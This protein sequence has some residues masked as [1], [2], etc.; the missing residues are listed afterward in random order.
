[1][2]R[3][4]KALEHKIEKLDAAEKKNAGR[5]KFD[6]RKTFPLRRRRGGIAERRL[7]SSYGPANDL[8][9][10]DFSASAG[11]GSGWCVMGK[12][13]KKKKRRRANRRCL[14][15]GVSRPLG[16]RTAATSASGASLKMGY[17]SPAGLRPARSEPHRPGNRSRKGLPLESIGTLRAVSSAAFQFSGR[18]RFEEKKDS[19]RCPAASDHASSWARHAARSAQLLVL[20]GTDESSRFLATRRCSSK[21]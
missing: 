19:A 20:D 4:V 17:F 8:R 18:R 5:W 16:G 21:Q 2:Q 7:H 13:K 6:F 12:K 14:I 1:V 10:L 9:R 15:D 3:R 11:G